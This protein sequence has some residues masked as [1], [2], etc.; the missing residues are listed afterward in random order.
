MVQSSESLKKAKAKYYQ[1]IKDDPDYKA[2]MQEKGKKYY[3]ENQEKLKE[4][5]KAYYEEHK[6]KINEKIKVKNENKKLNN[7][8]SK[9][10]SMNIEDLAKI[11]ITKK[12]TKLLDFDD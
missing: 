6:E 10:E 8:I 5:F 9:L 2:K 12:K 4:K 11:L 3:M 7:V 1:K